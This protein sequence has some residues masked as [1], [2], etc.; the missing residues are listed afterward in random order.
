M[1][2][3]I[4]KILH[5]NPFFGFFLFHYSVISMIYIFA[6]GYDQQPIAYFSYPICFYTLIFFCVWFYQQIKKITSHIKQNKIYKTYKEN[7]FIQMKLNLYTATFT[8]GILGILKLIAGIYYRSEWFITFAFYYL[9]LSGMRLL[10]L[11]DVKK[12][13]SEQNQVKAYQRV[14]ICAILLLAMNFILSGMIIL[15]IVQNQVVIYPN[16]LIYLVALYDFYLIISAF[17]HVF[18]YR[19]SANPLISAS[20]YINLTVA[21]ISMISLETS[22]LT[23][24]GKEN[25]GEFNTIMIACSGFVVCVINSILAL[26]MLRQ[27]TRYLKDKKARK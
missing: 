15:I 10:L 21:M 24:F 20:K 19:K 18:R 16:Y 12:D 9:L 22:M 17:I 7:L 23:Q 2:K 14:R 1:K 8:N 25:S 13:N 4:Q 27:A 26:T 5:P 3:I 6:N 11:R